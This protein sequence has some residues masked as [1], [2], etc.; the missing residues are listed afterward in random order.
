[1]ATRGMIVDLA[2]ISGLWASGEDLLPQANVCSISSNVCKLAAVG[3][4]WDRAFGKV[5]D[6]GIVDQKG[7]LWVE[8]DE[9]GAI[10][11]V[12][13]AFELF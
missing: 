3:L 9:K 4:G 10:R 6:M 2:M 8:I 13:H 7:K 5:D 11:P 1:M 12:W